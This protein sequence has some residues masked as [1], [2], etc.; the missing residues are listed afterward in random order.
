[1][2][3]VSLLTVVLVFVL[4]GCEYQAP[5]AEKGNIPVDES[6]LGLWEQVPEKNKAADPE[7]RML[8]LK[9][10]ETEYLVHYPTGKN[11]MYFRGYPLMIDGMTYM[12]IQLI[13][14]KNGDVEKKDRRFHVVS[15]AL[16]DSLLEIRTLNSWLVDKNLKDSARL[17]EAFL[18]N[19][20]NKDLFKDPG[21]FR[22]AQKKG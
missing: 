11:G 16:S 12:Q 19:K 10:T 6:I 21:K 1:M 18:K 13:G 17:M 2:K 4:A 7:E 20:D 14:T 9:Y 3:Y 15:Y 8:V 22:K 5:L